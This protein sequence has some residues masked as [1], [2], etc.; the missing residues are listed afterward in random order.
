M[1]KIFLDK[2]TGFR[3]KE[4]NKPIVIRDK[5]GKI[6][7]STETLVPKVKK[8]NL[9][10]GI[11]LFVESGNFTRMDEP[12]KYKLP[13]LPSPDRKRKF[14]TDFKV[15]FAVNPHKCTINWLDETITFD[16]SLREKSIPEMSFILFH[17][18]GHARY[19]V[20]KTASKEKKLK[21]EKNADL[22]SVKCLLKQGYNPSQ[23]GKAPITSL[24][25]LQEER[26][27]NVVNNILK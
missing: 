8:F 13:R 10:A 3:V 4:P 19:G 16:N 6:F 27:W 17:E 12:V 23:I 5:R 15:K 11:L 22:F 26:Q 25:E 9:P 14:P 2:V 18:F 1:R 24:S 21:A 7:Y 20:P